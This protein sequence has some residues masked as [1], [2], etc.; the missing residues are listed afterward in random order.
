MRGM[1]K[2]AMDLRRENGVTIDDNAGMV[3]CNYVGT[4]EDIE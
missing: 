4:E 2:M 1:T 3:L